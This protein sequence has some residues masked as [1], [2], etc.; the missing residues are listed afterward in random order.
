M[1]QLSFLLK[2]SFLE[3]VSFFYGIYFSLD[4]LGGCTQQQEGNIT[5][6][7]TTLSEARSRLVATFS[8]E[9]VFFA[10]G[11]TT[12]GQASNRVDI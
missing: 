12:K 2:I 3:N 5:H 9:L 11:N 4:F 7:T 10:G 6:T 1:R 8:N